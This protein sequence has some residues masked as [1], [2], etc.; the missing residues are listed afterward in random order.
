MKD[1]TPK[2]QGQ[3]L[4]VEGTRSHQYSQL[5]YCLGKLPIGEMDAAVRAWMTLHSWLRIG[6]A[7]QRVTDEQ[8]MASPFL[9][10]LSVEH[11]RKGLEI[12]EREGLISRVARGSRREV[13][14]VAK[15][16]GAKEKPPRKAASLPG[17]Y[18]LPG[19]DEPTVEPAAQW[20][21][22]FWEIVS[23]D[24]QLPVPGN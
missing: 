12:L 4:P 22:S 2:S 10:G 13:A 7:S 11:A 3:A 20:G 9:A 23:G 16:A 19:L 1:T 15:L 24:H 17:V 5:P 21:K 18:R 8:L 14:V 6:A